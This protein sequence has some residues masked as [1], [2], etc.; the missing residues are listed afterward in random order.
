MSARS[1]TVSRLVRA[2]V[3]LTTTFPRTIT[4]SSSRVGASALY[5]PGSCFGTETERLK[6]RATSKVPQDTK[7]GAVARDIGVVALKLQGNTIAASEDRPH[8]DWEYG[9]FTSNLITGRISSLVGHNSLVTG[10]DFHSANLISAASDGTCRVWDL[11]SSKTLQIL[12]H[13]NCSVNCLQVQGHTLATGTS[14]TTASIW[15]LKTYKQEFVLSGHTASIL[16]LALDD[17]V[18]A[19]GS[20]DNTCRIWNIEQGVC[21]HVLKEHTA[22]ISCLQFTNGS[23]V[24]GSWDKTA[25]SWDPTTG[26]LL[27]NFVHDQAVLALQFE[28]NILV[29]ATDDR[30]CTVWD[31]NTGEKLRT[32]SGHRDRINCLQIQ[33]DLL[34]TGSSDQD[35]RLWNI[36]SGESK[37]V[38]SSV[39]GITRLALRG[40]TLVIGSSGGSIAV[41][42]LTSL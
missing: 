37:I 20:L 35:V 42:D 41:K 3:P 32:L 12:S 22:V 21:K 13:G 29:T 40:N 34:V 8:G 16:C 17:K 9:L 26:K 18:L 27:K 31:L 23:L 33:G 30:V 2:F 4:T 7:A 1:Y 19:T 6:T 5:K 24:T 25:R 28:D 15:D 14:D 11:S 36:K 38:Y 39:Y 10:L